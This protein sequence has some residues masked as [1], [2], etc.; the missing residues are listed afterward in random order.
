MKKIIFPLIAFVVL[1]GCAKW[2]EAGARAGC[3]K[4][5]PDDKAKADECYK[6]AKQHYDATIASTLGRMMG[7]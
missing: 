5:F 1:S 4:L 6:D 3:E 7:K 2:D